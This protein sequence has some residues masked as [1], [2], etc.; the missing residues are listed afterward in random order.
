LLDGADEEAGRALLA[1][2]R[3]RRFRRNESIVHEGDPGSSVHLIDKG[4]VAVRVT[5]P[6]GEVATLRIM[7]AGQHFGDIA[8]LGAGR[9]TATIT[10]LEPVE[11]LEIAG[12]HLARF[13]EAN[14]SV[15]RSITRALASQVASLSSALLE[16]MYLPLPKRIARRL[17]ELDE[18]YQGKPIP[19]TQDDIAGLSGGTRQSVNQQLSDWRESGWIE[20]GRGRVTV[21]DRDRIERSGR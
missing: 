4:F 17:L 8:M 3:R 5:T 10:A 2:A 14:R 16:A 18:V 20:L 21:I 15:E 12:D 9:R 6:N 1:T 13:V 7:R 19:L 11:T